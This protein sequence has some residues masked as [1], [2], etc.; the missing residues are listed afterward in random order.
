[1]YKLI[2]VDDEEDVREGVSQEIDWHEYGFEVL[3]KAENGKEA[4]DLVERLRPDVVVTDI[5]MPFM[6]GLQLAEAIRRQFPATRIIIL[7]GFDEFE[8]AQ[9]A[10]KLHIDE[11]VLKPFSAVELIDVL[12]KV[13]N[14][15]DEEAAHREN[16]QL[17][18]ESYR[19]SLPVLREVFLSSLLTR[20]LPREDTLAKAAEYGVQLHG[21]EFLISVMCLDQKKKD[22]QQILLFAVK[23]I[24]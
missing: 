8:Y 20:Q 13:K 14:R 16:N 22:E 15:M 21:S 1:M 23:N 24:A 3:A 12:I 2:L 6:D 9:K 7:T 18:R 4:F 19:K 5:K 17:L 10:V 11:Y